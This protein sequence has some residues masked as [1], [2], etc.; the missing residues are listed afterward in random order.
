MHTKS[1]FMPFYAYQSFS[2]LSEHIMLIS[3]RPIMGH[4]M[5]ISSRTPFYD[6]RTK[7]TAF[8]AYQTGYWSINACRSLEKN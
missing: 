2:C 7:S 5:L 3:Q 1:L 4:F 6:C 8:N